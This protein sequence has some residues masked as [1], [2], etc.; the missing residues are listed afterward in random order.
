ME[1]ELSQFLDFIQNF[2]PLEM[3]DVMPVLPHIQLLSCEKK[4]EILG[5]G[6]TCKG[7]YFVI[8]GLVRIYRLNEGNDVTVDFMGETEFFTDYESLMMNKECQCYVE[9]IETTRLLYL[10]YDKL[11]EGYNNSHMLERLGRLMV[12][13]ALTTLISR[14]NDKLANLRSEQKYA[15]FEAQNKE[16]VN[17]IPLKH[18]ASFLGI[19]PESLSRIRRQRVN[20]FS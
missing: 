3:D 12:E 16:L 11:L 1:K 9:T 8:E 17:R 19:A 18:L 2:V 13:R 5:V 10:P 4:E 6:Q 15:N 20:S 14:S 7:V